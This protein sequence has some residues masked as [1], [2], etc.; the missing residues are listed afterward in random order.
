[1][2]EPAL[3]LGH[4]YYMIYVSPFSHG[5]YSHVR[6]GYMHQMHGIPTP[7]LEKNFQILRQLFLF[8]IK[9]RLKKKL[10]DILLPTKKKGTNDS[11][12]VNK[13]DDFDL[14]IIGHNN[15]YFKWDFT[16]ISIMIL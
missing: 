16:I 10:K 1:M 6:E 8:F 9:L 14:Q 13:F 5:V 11:Y 2:A 3:G 15:Y 12:L 7:L 4:I